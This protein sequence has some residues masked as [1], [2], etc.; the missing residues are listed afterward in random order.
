MPRFG[1][2]SGKLGH[3]PAMNWGRKAKKNSAVLGFSARNPWIIN[4]FEESACREPCSVALFATRPPL[5]SSVAAPRQT[6]YKAPTSFT[7]AN[8]LG[9]DPKKSG[10]PDGR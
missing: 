2:E 1:C 3:Y 9:A 6:R 5:P 10:K 8:S 4:H 7:A